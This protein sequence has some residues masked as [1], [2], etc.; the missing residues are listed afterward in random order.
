MSQSTG[1]TRT[2]MRPFAD[3]SSDHRIKMFKHMARLSG[4]EHTD[5]EDGWERRDARERE[6]LAWRH[7]RWRDADS[8]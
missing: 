4:V 2:P 3:E 8:R 6:L 5:D 1:A 7:P